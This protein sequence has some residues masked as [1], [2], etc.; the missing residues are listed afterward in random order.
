MTDPLM[1]TGTKTTPQM[2]KARPD[3]VLNNAG[4]YVFT[5]SDDARLHRFLT[6]G[7]TGGTFYVKERPLT[8]ENAEF[9]TDYARRDSI[10]LVH[11]AREI[12]VAGRA[13]RNNP[14]LYALAAASKLGDLEG[15]RQ[16]FAALPD[17]ARTGTH[18]YQFAA[19]RELF[20]GWGRGTRRAVGNW[21][22]SKTPEDLAYQMVKY[23]QREGWTHRDLLRLS[24]P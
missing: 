4:G 8:V 6:L 5:T 23:R 9:I 19:Y 18:L 16:A 12:S 1:K 11:H 22:L 20:G 10:A 7:T 13:P 3:Q 2:E 24:H 17:I 15:R 21:Y 14:A